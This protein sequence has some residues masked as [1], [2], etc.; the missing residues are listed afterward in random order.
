MMYLECGGR[1]VRMH[2]R[3]VHS[4]CPRPVLLVI[5]VSLLTVHTV[6]YTERENM[7]Q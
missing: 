5:P 7:F 3:N 4:S 1:V 2:N 6:K